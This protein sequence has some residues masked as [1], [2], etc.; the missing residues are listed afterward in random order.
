MAKNRMK[1]YQQDLLRNFKSYF[2]EDYLMILGSNFDIDNK[3]N[4]VTTITRKHRKSFHLIN[5]LLMTE[6]LNVDI[7]ELFTQDNMEIKKAKTYHDKTDE[8][9]NVYRSK[10]LKLISYYPN[11]SKSYLGNLD[12]ATYTWLNRYDKK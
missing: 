2:G 8:E 10:W 3:F 6:Y 4:W 12:T 11:S 7:N 5:H 9:K 1:I